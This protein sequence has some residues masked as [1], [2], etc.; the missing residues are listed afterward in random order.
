MDSELFPE[1]LTPD[2]LLNGRNRGLGALVPPLE[3]WLLQVGTVIDPDGFIPSKPP[4]Q[5]PL[6]INSEEH[7]MRIILAVTT[8]ELTA[9]RTQLSNQ[10]AFSNLPGVSIRK[11]VKGRLSQAIFSE[12]YSFVPVQDRWGLWPWCAV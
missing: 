12:G 1:L 6:E 8:I 3:R 9:F 5:G 11:S 4:G 10:W 2:H 7:V